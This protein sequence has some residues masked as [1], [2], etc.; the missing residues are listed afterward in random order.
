MSAAA[1]A[2]SPR[3]A[4][5]LLSRN[6]ARRRVDLW[7]FGCGNVGGQLLEIL[8]NRGSVIREREAI[9][10]RVVAI[11]TT[12]GSWG[13]A[14]GLSTGSFREAA[15]VPTPPE[16]L[17]RRMAL[18]NHPIFVDLTAAQDVGSLYRSVADAGLAIVSANKLPFVA[19]IH[20]YETLLEKARNGRGIFYETTVGADLPVLAP[21]IDRVRSGDDILRVEGSLSGTLGLLSDAVS[22]GVPLD[23]AVLDAK[24]RG[25]TEPDPAEDLSGLDVARKAVIIARELGLAVE[26]SNVELEGFVSSAVLESAKTIGLGAALAAETPRFSERVAGFTRAS[27]V[28]RYL[29]TID[30]RA[31]TVR[32]GPVA[33]AKDHPAASLSGTEALVSIVSERSGA[34][35]VTIRGPGAGGAVT[36]SGVLADILRASRA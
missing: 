21:I 23:Q 29:A 16:L 27:R 14:Q 11:T 13:D 25:T 4:P 3:I 35:A 9:D 20:H 15:P 24:A 18:Q 26:L 12:R 33:V 19:A 8:H 36:A 1:L 10:L 22:R 7:L 5:R 2:E 34:S 28:L 32:V 17:L 30:P 6:P 31:R